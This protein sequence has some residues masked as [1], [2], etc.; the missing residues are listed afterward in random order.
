VVN[1]CSMDCMCDV[2]LAKSSLSSPI[3]LP[4]K[5]LLDAIHLMAHDMAQE[6]PE[7]F[8]S[9]QPNALLAIGALLMLFCT[10]YHGQF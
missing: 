8:N 7:F 1:F 3:D 5:D 4:S 10:K 6:S 2:E 9:L